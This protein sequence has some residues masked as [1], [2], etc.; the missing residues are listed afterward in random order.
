M[1]RPTGGRHAGRTQHPVA[2]QSD[3][4]DFLGQRNELVGSNHSPHRVPPAREG[5]E[6]EKPQAMCRNLGLVV[7]FKLLDRYC[8]AQ[9]RP[10]DRK[11]GAQVHLKG[12]ARAG[13]F[14][15]PWLMFAARSRPSAS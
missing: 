3:Q 1:K 2:E 9:F 8:L 6:A 13:V 4:A 7:H 15:H 5:L 12:L 11:R 10:V 14:L